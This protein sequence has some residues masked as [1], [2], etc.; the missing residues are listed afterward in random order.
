MVFFL[1][2]L[3][4]FVHALSL[5]FVQSFIL[6]CNLFT[7]KYVVQYKMGIKEERKCTLKRK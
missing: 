5:C 4:F 6:Y 2:L 7:Y 1:F 3:S